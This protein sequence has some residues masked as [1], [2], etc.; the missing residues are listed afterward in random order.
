MQSLFDISL[1]EAIQLLADIATIGALIFAIKSFSKNARINEA[2][3]IN[4]I[5]ESFQRNRQ[6]ILDNPKQLKAYASQREVSE[7]T[8]IEESIGSFDLNHAYKIYQLYEDK[9]IPEDKWEQFR[10]DMRLSFSRPLVQKR[11]NEAKSYFSTD[12]QEYIDTQ[13]LLDTKHK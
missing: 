5:F 9:L 10:A 1:F 2:M 12:F 4:N 3:F 7:E 13:I 8:L 11:W 6:A